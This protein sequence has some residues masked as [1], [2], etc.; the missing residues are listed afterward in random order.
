MTL[1]NVE[2]SGIVL[3]KNQVVG[4]ITSDPPDGFH[5]HKFIWEYY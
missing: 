3:A 5:F 2:Y 4:Q 1:K